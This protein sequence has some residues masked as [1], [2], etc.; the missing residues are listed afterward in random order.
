M[1][2]NFVTKARKPQGS[3]LICTSPILAGQ[4][5]KWAKPRHGPTR[6]FCQDCQPLPSHLTANS[7]L[8]DLYSAQESISTAITE[9][10]LANVLVS[11]RDAITTA[12]EDRDSYQESLDNMPEQLQSGPT[13]EEIQEKIDAIESW[14]YELENAESNLEDLSPSEDIDFSEAESARDALEL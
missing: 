14:I 7:R 3:C 12:E 13:G 11:L 9:G 8:A 1:K 6:L 2:L 5:Y 4:S 10:I